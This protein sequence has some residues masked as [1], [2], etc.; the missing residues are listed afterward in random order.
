MPTQL[1]SKISKPSPGLPT[2]ISPAATTRRRLT[3]TPAYLWLCPRL[4]LLATHCLRPPHFRQAIFRS[5]VAIARSVNAFT[6][7]TPM[8]TRRTLRTTRMPTRR[9]PRARCETAYHAIPMVQL[10]WSRLS[11]NTVSP[12]DDGVQLHNDDHDDN[13]TKASGPEA[14]PVVDLHARLNAGGSSGNLGGRS[15]TTAVRAPSAHTAMVIMSLRTRSSSA[16]VPEAR[17]PRT[18]RGKS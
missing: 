12:N 9:L 16:I 10:I 6:M 8:A 5:P 18:A 11:T 3:R 1:L 7:P 4:W 14:E 17:I 13:D 15:S 2:R